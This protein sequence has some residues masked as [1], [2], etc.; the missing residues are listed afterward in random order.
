MTLLAMRFHLS[1]HHLPYLSASFSCYLP[2]FMLKC[3]R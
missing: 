1:F 3:C 2:H